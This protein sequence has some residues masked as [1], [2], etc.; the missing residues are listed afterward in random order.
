MTLS[1]PAFVLALAMANPPAAATAAEAPPLTAGACVKHDAARDQLT[2]LDRVVLKRSLE[3]ALRSGGLTL[4]DPCPDPWVVLHLR[5]GTGIFVSLTSRSGEASAVA[6]SL[7]AVPGVYGELVQ[8]ILTGVELRAPEPA[9]A[10][11]AAPQPPAAPLAQSPAVPVLPGGFAAQGTPHLSPAVLAPLDL[12]K[13]SYFYLTIGGARIVGLSEDPE[14]SS[15]IGYRYQAGHWGVDASLSTVNLGGAD[16]FPPEAFHIAIIR[17]M[18][19]YSLRP[20]ADR[21]VYALAGFGA[22]QAM[23]DDGQGFGGELAGDGLE[24]HL[25][26]GYEILRDRT[27]RLF[28]ETLFTIPFFGVRPDN[29]G[30]FFDDEFSGPETSFGP[31]VSVM[32]GFG[33]S[34]P[35]YRAYGY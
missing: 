6:P 3:A 22:G 8:A 14:L 35:R 32:I 16:S 23:V 4:T 21:T 5:Q 10:P 25:G 33:W 2:P 29:F 31:V 7:R 15:G 34:R 1:L 12:G 26:V 27:M 13:A 9:A 24:G 19:L 17:V 30:D 18:A 20:K 28:F 11:P